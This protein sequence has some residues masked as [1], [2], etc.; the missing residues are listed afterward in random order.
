[1]SD[2]YRETEYYKKFSA[3]NPDMARSLCEKIQKIDPI[4]VMT[5]ETKPYERELY[6]AYKIM[7]GY[8]VSDQ[9]LFA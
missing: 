2:T 5:E 8:G 4:K 9:D 1:M 7:R 6:E 3:E